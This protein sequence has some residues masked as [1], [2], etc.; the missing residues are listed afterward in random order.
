MVAPDPRAACKRCGRPIVFSKTL[1]RCACFWRCAK[2]VCVDADDNARDDAKKSE[3]C[4]EPDVAK[5]VFAL[6]E[7]VDNPAE[8][9]RLGELRRGYDDTGG[10]QTDRQILFRREQAERPFVNLDEGQR[11]RRGN[12]RRS[13]PIRETCHACAPTAHLMSFA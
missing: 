9:N 3:E 12:L 8:Q 7:G 13:N 1:T 2:P 4:P 6:A 10:R 11:R 5:R